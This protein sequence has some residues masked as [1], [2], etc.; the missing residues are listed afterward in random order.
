MILTEQCQNKDS[1]SRLAL[2][3][4]IKLKVKVERVSLKIDVLSTTKNC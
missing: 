4:K 1:T 3:K 2:K